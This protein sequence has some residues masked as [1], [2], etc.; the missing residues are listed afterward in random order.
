MPAYVSCGSLE[1]WFKKGVGIIKDK[2]NIDVAP[3][4]VSLV[5]KDYGDELLDYHIE[6]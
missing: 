2:G 4:G 3:A 5:K 1:V 6:P